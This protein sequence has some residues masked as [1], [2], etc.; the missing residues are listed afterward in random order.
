MTEGEWGESEIQRA[1]RLVEEND[2]RMDIQVV[3]AG[4]G[5]TISRDGMMRIGQMYAAGRHNAPAQKFWSIDVDSCIAADAPE[6]PFWLEVRADPG[7]RTAGG[8]V[9]NMWVY[10]KRVLRNNAADVRGFYAAQCIADWCRRHA[11]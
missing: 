5:K 3:V 11:G 1:V 9:R 2:E 4:D 10:P 8:P 7:M 6:V